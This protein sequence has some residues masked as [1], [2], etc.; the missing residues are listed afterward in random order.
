MTP[1]WV[2]GNCGEIRDL[3]SMMSHSDRRDTCLRCGWQRPGGIIKYST[4]ANLMPRLLSERKRLEGGQKTIKKKLKDTN[5]KINGLVS[6]MRKGKL[7]DTN[8]IERLNGIMSSLQGEKKTLAA[9]I[10]TISQI[11]RWGDAKN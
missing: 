2:C 11:I 3:I 7:K 9:R 8:E 5:E 4:A 10:D 6:K 1:V